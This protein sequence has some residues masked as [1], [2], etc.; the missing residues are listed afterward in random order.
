VRWRHRAYFVLLL[1]VGAVISIGSWPYDDPSPYG[2]LFKDFGDTAAGLALRNTPRAVPLLVLGIAGLIAAG[3]AALAPR[4]GNVWPTV[5]VGVL[6]LGAILPVV[7]YGFLTGYLD[8]PR[9]TF[10]STGRTRSRR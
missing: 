7:S 10:R 2:A 1:V 4:L 3:V 5:V 9:P 8:R 6:V